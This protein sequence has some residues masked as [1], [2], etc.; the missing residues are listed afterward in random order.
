MKAEIAIGQVFVDRCIEQ[1]LKRKL[2]VDAAA[3]AKY[4]ART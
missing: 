1:V 2:G 3:T 4:G